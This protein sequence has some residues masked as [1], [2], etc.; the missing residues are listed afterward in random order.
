MDK[1][2]HLSVDLET[3][4]TEPGAVITQIGVSAF[5]A[6]HT[7][8]VTLNFRIDPQSALDHG[9]HVSWSTISWWLQQAEKPRVDMAKQEGMALAVA[10]IELR[11]FVHSNCTEDVKVW[12]NGAGFD[13][14]LL[15]AAY[16]MCGLG[17]KIPWAF[18]NVRDMRTLMALVPSSLRVSPTVEHDAMYDADAQALSIQNALAWLALEPPRPAI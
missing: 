1:L 4:G 5:A 7:L 18:R 12:G 2:E 10:L 17:K 9:L 6:D 14:T 3:L 8:R 15:E 13:I 11:R 16:R